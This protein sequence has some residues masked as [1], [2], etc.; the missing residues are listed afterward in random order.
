MN[1]LEAPMQNGKDALG[2]RMALE[3]H[4]FVVGPVIGR[5]S[6]NQGFTVIRTEQGG[7]PWAAKCTNEGKAVGV[8]FDMLNDE[9][10][11]LRELS[12]SSIVKAERFLEAPHGA[13]MVMELCP[14]TRLDLLLAKGG[15]LCSLKRHSVMA[16]ILSGVEHMHS[17]RVVHMDIHCQNI[18][19][20]AGEPGEQVSN[21]RIVD[22][23]SSHLLSRCS[24]SSKHDDDLSLL[25][26]TDRRFAPPDPP[27]NHYQ[28]DIFA[29]GLVEAALIAGR[30]VETKDVVKDSCLQ[31]PHDLFQPCPRMRDHLWSA[32]SLDPQ[33]RATAEAFHKAMPSVDD[34]HESVYPRRGTKLSL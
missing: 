1:T 12:H 21:V 32:L 5:S 15:T 18:I 28:C 22:F 14:G 2:Y 17:K 19:A 9:Y 25:E 27:G 4:G 3:E 16:G 24:G 8:L 13:A 26:N 31:V 34:W 29:C 7:S 6:S 10:N 20:D 23:G 30:T 11:I 33:K